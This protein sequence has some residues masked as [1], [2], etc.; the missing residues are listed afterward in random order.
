[1]EGDNSWDVSFELQ[2][3]TFQETVVMVDGEQR[4]LDFDVDP[5]MSQKGSGWAT[6]GPPCPMAKP[7]AFLLTLLTRWLPTC[8]KRACRHSGAMTTTPFRVLKR[9]K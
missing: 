8:R 9:R 6:S 5:V 7:L 4:Q 2:S 1:M 3:F